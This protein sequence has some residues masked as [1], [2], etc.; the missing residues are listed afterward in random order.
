MDEMNFV[1]SAADP[2][3]W[4]RPAIEPDGSEC[5]ECVLCH[6]DDILAVGTDP[7]LALEGSK[8][9]TVK[10]E[11]DKIETPEMHLGAK[12]Q[13]KSTDGLPCWAV[14][15]E[16]CVEAAVETAK[17]LIAK[18]NL[19]W[20]ITKGAGT[21]MNITFVPEPDDSAKLGPKDITLCQE[22]IAMLR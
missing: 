8:G 16:E 20:S 6:V 4:I 12:L 13:N 2:D 14:T 3:V 10:F 19:K 15:S 18:S 1:S 22:M 7:R 11:N 5:H 21:P 9:G 17:A